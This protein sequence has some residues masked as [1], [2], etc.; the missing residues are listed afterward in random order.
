MASLTVQAQVLVTAAEMM[1]VPN[2][3]LSAT[4]VTAATVASAAVAVDKRSGLN[5]NGDAATDEC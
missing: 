3:E 1:V 5:R 4:T 2:T